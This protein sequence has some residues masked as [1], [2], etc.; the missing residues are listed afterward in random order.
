MPGRAA[1]GESAQPVSVFTFH[2][3]LRVFQDLRLRDQH[4]VRPRELVPAKAFPQQALGT[5]P[6]D[7]PSQA[8][9]SG[10]PE[11]TVRPR[12]VDGHQREEGT[13]EPQAFP[14]DALE[15]RPR[16]Q[17][18]RRPE[19]WARRAGGRGYAPIRLRPFWRRRFSTRRPPLVRMRTRNP[20]V[21]FRLRLFGWNVRF[22]LSPGRLSSDPQRDASTGQRSECSEI[23]GGL[24]I[25]ARLEPA[26]GP[27]SGRYAV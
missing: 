5:V 4:Q 25:R 14:Q 1:G 15:L 18:F 13:V 10:E 27:L 16:A 21:R 26:P 11:A 22:M 2:L 12:V 17:P 23:D 24:S 19:P 7:R 8:A 3:G 6:G 9:G 20:W